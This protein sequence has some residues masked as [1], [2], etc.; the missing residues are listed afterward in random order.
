MVYCIVAIVVAGDED[1]HPAGFCDTQ[2]F[3]E[4]RIG[5]VA[6]YVAARNDVG[7]AI[8]KRKRL[9]QPIRDI[10]VLYM[11]TLSPLAQEPPQR[12]CRFHAIDGFAQRSNGKR[13]L[14]CAGTD[15]HNAFA[16]KIAEPGQFAFIPLKKG[17]T[18]VNL[19]IYGIGDPILICT[20][21][22][23]F[24]LKQR[25]CIGGRQGLAVL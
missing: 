7:K 3:R 20:Q 16:G 17:L 25:L 19:R 14:A 24:R 10:Q 9:H 13:L 23:S 22:R 5:G 18:M 8:F 15:V 1:Y 21:K 4:F 11:L 12:P 6:E 2:H